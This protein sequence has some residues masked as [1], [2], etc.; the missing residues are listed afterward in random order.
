M[1]NEQIA[2]NIKN[3]LEIPKDLIAIK[4]WKEEPSTVQKYQGNAF[5][6]MC[7]QICE[8]LATGK[9]FHTNQEHC[10]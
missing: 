5:P 8:V 7:T 2:N 9:T 4:A 10:F 3:I 6:G 1:T